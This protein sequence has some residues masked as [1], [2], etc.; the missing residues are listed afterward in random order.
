MS[1]NSSCQEEGEK[2]ARSQKTLTDGFSILRVIIAKSPCSSLHYVYKNL[3]VTQV[4]VSIEYYIFIFGGIVKVIYM[5]SCNFSCC[6]RKKNI[7]WMH[8]CFVFCSSV[9]VLRNL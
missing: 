7:K 1:F 2:R 8:G 5:I 4:T 9:V 6:K 3:H